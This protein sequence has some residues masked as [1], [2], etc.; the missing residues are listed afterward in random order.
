MFIIVTV[1]DHIEESTWSNGE[2]VA[3]EKSHSLGPWRYILWHEPGVQNI[4][5]WLRLL[6][7]FLLNIATHIS[8]ARVS[9]HETYKALDALENPQGLLFCLIVHK[10][11]RGPSTMSLK[12]VKFFGDLND[13]S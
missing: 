11:L 13:K 10:L 12:K 5:L 2:A 7:Y 8:G 9:D 3:I 1:S 4:Q 6:R